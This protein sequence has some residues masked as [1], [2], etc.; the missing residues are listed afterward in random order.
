MG[1]VLETNKMVARE[2]YKVR[3]EKFETEV[4]YVTS[5]TLSPV[6]DKSIAMGYVKTENSEDGTKIA[7]DIRGKPYPATVVK[8]P[9]VPHRYYR[10]PAAKK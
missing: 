10:K 5:G 8:M 9:F 3:D 2:G 7:V 6:L 4:G 1:L